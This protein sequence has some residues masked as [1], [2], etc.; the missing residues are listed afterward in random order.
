MAAILLRTCISYGAELF[1]TLPFPIRMIIFATGFILHKDGWALSP[2]YDINPATDKNGLQLNIDETNN[3]LDF[4]V[5]KSVGF[6]FQLNDAEMNTIISEV[7][8]SVKTWKE[9]AT[10]IGIPRSQVELMA[11]A[12]YHSVAV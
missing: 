10:E 2:A 12:F 11:P 5:A 6:Y 7:L 8:T 3:T 4:N 9:V 1:S